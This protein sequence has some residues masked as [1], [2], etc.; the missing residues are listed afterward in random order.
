VAITATANITVRY[1]DNINNILCS[2]KSCSQTLREKAIRHF[3]LGIYRVTSLTTLSQTQ[4]QSRSFLV[5]EKSRGLV[6]KNSKIIYKKQTLPVPQ[7]TRD[8][9]RG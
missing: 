7:P 8:K 6:G 1:F 4:L 5:L 2:L 9:K 3:H